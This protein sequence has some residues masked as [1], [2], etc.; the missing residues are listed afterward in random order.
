MDGIQKLT[1]HLQEHDPY[2]C[3]DLL[4]AALAS[5][6][7]WPD[8][9]SPRELIQD[10]RTAL[11]ASVFETELAVLI[12]MGIL[13]DLGTEHTHRIRL[14]EQAGAPVEALLRRMVQHQEIPAGTQSMTT[15]AFLAQFVQYLRD[16]DETVSV[17]EQEGDACLLE[18]DGK[19]YRLLLT[20]SPYWLP[21]A[22][23]GSNGEGEDELFVLAFGPFAARPLDVMYSYFNLEEFRN[24]VALCDP[25]AQEKMNLCKG[26]LPV[27]LDWFYRDRFRGKLHISPLFCEALHDMGL[28]RYNDE[29]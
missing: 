2:P 20:F 8:G 21:L 1:A 25:W 11:G 9:M 23:A 13:E 6:R 29:Y 16:A 19:K 15:G 7:H 27:Y 17:L 28:M 12:Q 24:Y 18:S 3:L 22:T 10:I 5:R 14:T 26:S 4:E